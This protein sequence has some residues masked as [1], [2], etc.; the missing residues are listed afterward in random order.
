MTN[1]NGV[2]PVTSELPTM[3]NDPRQVEYRRRFWEAL[4]G[5]KQSAA[6]GCHVLPEETYRDLCRRYAELTPPVAGR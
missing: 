2:S 1:E 6:D 3:T 4:K 5:M